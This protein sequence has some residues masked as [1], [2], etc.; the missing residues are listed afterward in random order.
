MPTC[1]QPTSSNIFLGLD[2]PNVMPSLPFATNSSISMEDH[3][4]NENCHMEP[5]L[6]D[7]LQETMLIADRI[8][9]S[10]HHAEIM[11]DTMLLQD[12]LDQRMDNLGVMTDAHCDIAIDPEL[13][14]LKP[15][16]HMRNTDN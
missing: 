6:Q 10:L 3:T 8:T 4:T 11:E 9:N 5:Q 7:R 13:L 2:W 1:D 14:T 12:D 16:R 15:P